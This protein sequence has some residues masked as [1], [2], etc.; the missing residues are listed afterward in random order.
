MATQ[1]SVMAQLQVTLA[2][3]QAETTALRTQLAES[4]AQ[5]LQAQQQSFA[6]QQLQAQELAAAKTK[7]ALQAELLKE[8][9][10]WRV[11]A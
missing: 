9:W 1:E 8:I 3:M 4:T 5:R 6:L 2:R 7:F 10:R 11:P